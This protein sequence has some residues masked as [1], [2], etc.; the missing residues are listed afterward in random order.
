MTDQAPAFCL[1]RATDARIEPMYG[2]IEY[3]H[4]IEIF[5]LASPANH[6]AIDV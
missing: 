5:E 1:S 4:N 2:F 3:S 6:H